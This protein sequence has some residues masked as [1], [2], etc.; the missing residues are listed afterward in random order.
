VPRAGSVP[1]GGSRTLVGSPVMAGKKTRLLRAGRKVLFS[2]LGELKTR[3]HGRVA[4][5]PGSHE[6]LKR[7]LCNRFATVPEFR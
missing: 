6:V 5:V 2:A 1:T 4:G 7:P 3:R